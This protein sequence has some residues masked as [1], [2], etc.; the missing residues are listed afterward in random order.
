MGMAAILIAVMFAW[1]A[2]LQT[3][4]LVGI[5]FCGAVAGARLRR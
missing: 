1:G 2:S 5:A 3:I 4:T